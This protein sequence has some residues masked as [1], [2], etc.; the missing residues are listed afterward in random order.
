MYL[1]QNGVKKR[2]KEISYFTG[3]VWRK[4]AF[5]SVAAST[6]THS[7]LLY[8]PVPKVPFPSLKLNEIAKVKLRGKVL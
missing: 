6:S 1:G 8:L 4:M 7:S 3:V 2:Q 5:P